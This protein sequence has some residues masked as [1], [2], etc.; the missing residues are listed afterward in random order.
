MLN[1]WLGTIIT[2]N[3]SQNLYMAKIL[4]CYKQN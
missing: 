4:T 1:D 3:V 2:A